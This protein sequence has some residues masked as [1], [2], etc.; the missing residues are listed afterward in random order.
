LDHLK[1]L[2]SPIAPTFSE[3]L[4]ID[5]QAGSWIFISGQAGGW[6]Q[7]SQEP[8]S[9]RLKAKTMSSWK[10]SPHLIVSSRR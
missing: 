3:T 8:A 6:L 4:R 9:F 2:P 7:E 10:A 1:H 5:T